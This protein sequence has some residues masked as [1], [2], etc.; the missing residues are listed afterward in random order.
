MKKEWKSIFQSTWLKIVLI[1]IMIIPMVYSGVFLGSMWDPYGNA[2]QMPVAIVDKDKA[3]TY[4]GTTLHVGKTLCDNLKDNKSMDF[5]FV[6][7]AEAKK[8]LKN[9]TYYMVVTIP[10]NFSHNA[11]TLLDSE[12]EKMLLQYA[13]NPGTNYIASKMDETAIRTMKEN[14]S[15]TITM[16]YADTLFDQVKTLSKGLQT[17][18]DGSK[19]LEDGVMQTVDGN[20]TIKNNL[21]TL[22]NST[23]DFKEGSKT[24]ET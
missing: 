6:K 4:N 5:Q 21:I 15:K 1:A 20:T 14:I 22:A 10:E 23:L 7:E 9:G 12:P 24:W 19:Q 3:V 17:A 8:G 2:D 16:T 13:T 18:S 11:T